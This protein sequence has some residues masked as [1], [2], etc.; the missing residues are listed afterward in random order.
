MSQKIVSSSSYART[1]FRKYYTTTRITAPKEIEKREYGFVFFDNQN[2]VRHISFRSEDQL[3]E[4]L[5]RKIPRHAYYSSAYYEIPDA[6]V[7]GEKRW[8]GADLVF[9]IDVDHIPTSCK[10]VHDRWVCPECG[11]SGYGFYEKCPFCG[12]DR[13]KRTIWVCVTCIEIARDEALKLVDILLSDFGL[14]DNEIFAV[15]SGHRGFHI[16]VDKEIFRE[17]SQDARREIADYVRGLGLNINFF[18]KP[19]GRSI[20]KYKYDVSSPGWRG[21]LARSLLT[22]LLEINSVEDLKELGFTTKRAKKVL[23]DIESSRE[24]GDLLSISFTKRELEKLL[25]KAL[26]SERC[27]IDEKVTI[28]TKRLIRLPGSLHGK[29]GLKVARLSISE[30]ENED[31][32]KKSIV[33]NGYA[34]IKADNLPKRVLDWNFDKQNKTIIEVPTYIAVYLILNGGYKL[35][36]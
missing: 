7:M 31:I 13:L 4:F 32:L 30:L 17:L 27:I 15:F 36:T 9:D 25:E 5:R 18:I 28:D 21:R 33:F 23:K 12:S 35:G 1:L 22:T 3:N 26:S 10:N 34:K 11:E 6:P 16:H 24:K 2:M 20:Y 19:T 29:T 8:L 14:S